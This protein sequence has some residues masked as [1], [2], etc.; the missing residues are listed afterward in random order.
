MTNG[1]MSP[2]D[3]ALW[4]T[5]QGDMSVKLIVQRDDGLESDLDMDVF[6]RD[7]SRFLMIETKALDL[8]RGKVLD[9]GAGAGVHS[10]E[11]QNRGRDIWSIDLA[12]H[13]VEIMNARGVRHAQL[14][15][16][17]DFFTGGFDTILMLMH[18]IGMVGTLNG[19]DKFLAHAKHLLKSDGIIVL[20]SL[21]VRLT[22]EVVHLNY[23]EANR[24]AGRYFGEIRFRFEYKGRTG[25]YF[26]WLHVDPVTLQSHAFQQGWESRVI[27]QEPDGDYLACLARNKET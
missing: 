21:D 7:K 9:V 20:D 8:C 16:I 6:F 26:S 1:A 23:Q 11:L 5:F 19:L 12:P 22:E 27:H 24:K 10:L 4:D 14:A 2:Y 18:G 17:F 3:L 15:N 25:D 13:A